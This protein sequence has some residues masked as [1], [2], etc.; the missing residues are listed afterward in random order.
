MHDLV[1][2]ALLLT[3]DFRIGGGLATVTLLAVIPT[4]LLGV[5]A[6]VVRN[7][8]GPLGMSAIGFSAAVALVG[9]AWWAVT[10]L[11]R[12]RAVEVQRQSE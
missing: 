2:D 3:F 10:R 4:A 11:A 12:R 6:W 5:A 8:P 9:P 7:E 1:L